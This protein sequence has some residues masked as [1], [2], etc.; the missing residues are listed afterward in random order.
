MT[1]DKIIIRKGTRPG[2][3]VWAALELLKEDTNS[4]TVEAIL[5]NCQIAE[6][7]ENVYAEKISG[8]ADEIKLFQMYNEILET[9][10]ENEFFRSA[11]RI[12]PEVA[13]TITEHIKASR[14]LN[15]SFK[16]GDRIIPW[17]YITSDIHL[18]DTT[19]S[20]DEEILYDFENLSILEFSLKY[21]VF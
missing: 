3:N 6:I 1:S 11:Y 7:L 5:A 2:A 15:D 13:L 17:Y 12:H 8:I 10:E 4:F 19:Y 18:A 9:G 20:T 14:L 16:N 21:V